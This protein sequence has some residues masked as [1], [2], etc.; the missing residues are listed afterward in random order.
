MPLHFP[1]AS[2]GPPGSQATSFPSLPG[3][4]EAPQ[5]SPWPPRAQ[6]SCTSPG[7]CRRDAREGPRSARS[8]APLKPEYEE[9]RA[10]PALSRPGRDKAGERTVQPPPAPTPPARSGGASLCWPPAD[11]GKLRGQRS[12]PAAPGRRGQS[13]GARTRRSRPSG[14]RFGP[15]AP[16]PPCAGRTG[17]PN[18]ASEQKAHGD[19]QTRRQTDTLPGTRRQRRGQRGPAAPLQPPP[20]P[21]LTCSSFSPT[22]CSPFLSKR[23]M[24]S[25][26]SRRC[27]PSGLTA[28]KVRSPAPPQAAR[29]G[30]RSEA[31]G[32]ARAPRGS[33][34]PRP[35]P[36]RGA[37]SRPARTALAEAG[38]ET[39]HQADHGGP[40]PPRPAPAAPPR[41]RPLAEP[42]RCGRRAAAPTEGSAA[43]VPTATR[44]AR[45]CPA[46]GVAGG[47]PARG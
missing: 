41:P 22:M 24:I 46:A 14:G 1:S 6:S 7:G 21:G 29:G 18:D 13:P 36:G 33:G 23:R 11:A 42:S 38:E 34:G 30:Q 25:P 12:R 16:T 3:S 45:R 19:T 5:H 9:H 28:T 35:P 47:G 2:R 8:A 26:T 27:T 4:R 17:R 32:A 44:G 20:P 10:E 31:R 15:W 40:G 43:A 39:Q 37:G